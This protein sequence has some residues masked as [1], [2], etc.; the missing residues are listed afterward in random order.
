M[1]HLIET[2]RAHLTPDLIGR[3][4]A[5]L[6]ESENSLAKTL[7]G[8]LPALLAGMLN[9]TGQPEAMRR[10]YQQIQDADPEVP[11][12]LADLLD[13]GSA[14]ANDPRD[15]AGRLIG[16]LFGDK[17]S[18]VVSSVAAFSGARTATVTALLGL[19]GALV[20]GVLRRRIDTDG[21]PAAG[22]ANL[23]RREREVIL[24]RLP[25][26]LVFILGLDLPAEPA[27]PPSG[28]S[29]RAWPLLLL[30]GL[31]LGLMAFLKNCSGQ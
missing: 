5:R 12:R 25:S 1:A 16:D 6:G 27:S 2:A 8:L 4:A 11:E 22:L 30:L 15:A 14:G 13:S 18:A 9:K 23:L 28:K 31:G 10:L 17:T 19:S 24:A 21:L 7:G 29:G 20:M 26:G 3:A